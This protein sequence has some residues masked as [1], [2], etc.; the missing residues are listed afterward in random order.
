MSEQPLTR[1]A[2]GLALQMLLLKNGASLNEPDCGHPKPL[3]TAESRER[4]LSR[5]SPGS[6]P[7]RALAKQKPIE[8][9]PVKLEL[10]KNG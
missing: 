9:K 4:T 1:E 5:R 2:A 8:P 3:P 7:G 10:V 6:T